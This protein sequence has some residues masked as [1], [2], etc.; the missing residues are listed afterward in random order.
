MN[1]ST[2]A[3]WSR[4]SPEQLLAS[5][6]SRP[7]NSKRAYEAD[8]RAFALWMGVASTVEAV[9]LLIDGGSGQARR[10]LTDYIAACQDAGRSLGTARRRVSGL[11]A[12]VKRASAYEIITWSI[13]RLK[14]PR[15]KLVRDT[16]GPTRAEF[17]RLIAYCESR[18]DAVGARDKALLMLL[19]F[20]GLRSSEA[21]SIRWPEDVDTGRYPRVNVR[22]KGKWDRQWVDMAIVTKAAV[23]RWVEW[24]GDYE[25][26]LF[27][28]LHRGEG[29]GPGKGRRPDPSPKNGGGIR[30]LS[31][32]GL[33]AVVR[34]IG[35]AC[36][37]KVR[38]HGL[39]HTGISQA[40]D[41]TGDIG[42]AMAL[43]RHRDSRTTMAYLDSRRT[44]R[45]AT[46]IVAAGQYTL[47]HYQ[48]NEPSNDN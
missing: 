29:D 11:L 16:A 37:V 7:A 36:G 23:E 46:E 12:I 38:P 24:R 6:L 13:D 43:A 19:C 40:F 4:T 33:Y 31:Y 15:S 34:E 47:S 35:R 22:P 14:L 30:Q 2:P 10:V 1:P 45:Q 9:R 17:E 41:L 39:R 8:L 27:V 20:S 21:L 3:D 5:H 32:P 48:P 25:G 26:P 44:M 42:Y 28:A 18:V